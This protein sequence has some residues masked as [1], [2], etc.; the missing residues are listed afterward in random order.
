[1]YG[2]F[3]CMGGL[4]EVLHAFHGWVEAPDNLRIGSIDTNYDVS[5]FAF[6]L[7]E[8]VRQSRVR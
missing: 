4:S 1:M 3:A 7:D 8:P 5:I 2:S 6:R